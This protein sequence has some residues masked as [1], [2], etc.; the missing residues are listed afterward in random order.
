LAAGGEAGLK[1]M[2]E[3][4]DVEIRTAMGLMG[5]TSL[6]QLN[7][8]WVRATQPVRPAGETNAYPWFETQL[9]PTKA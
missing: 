6:A 5:V 8:S 9:R 3:L 4:M 7:P 2:L 1:R